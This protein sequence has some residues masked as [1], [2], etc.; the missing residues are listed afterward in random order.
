MHQAALL[1]HSLKDAQAYGW[2][3]PET[4]PF[5]WENMSQAVQNHVRSLNFAHRVKLKDKHVDFFNAL[6]SLVD[7][8]TVKAVDVKGKER[9]LKAENIV[10]AV[11]LRPHVLDE[12]PGAREYAITSDDIFWRHEPPG[13]TLVIGASYIALECGGFLT[14]LGFDTTIMV[15]SRCLRSFDQEMAELVT[16][17]MASSG[18]R[19]LWHCQPQRID[20]GSDGRLLVSFVDRKGEVMQDEFNTVMLATGRKAETKGL[21]LEGVGV[22]LNAE[23]NKVVG[24]H[25]GDN[26]RSSVP[27]IYAIG[28]VL[29]GQP[30]LTPVAI[31]AGKM[32][33]HRLFGKSKLQMEYNKVATTVFTP[34]E[35]GCVG[36]AEEDALIKYDED[37]LEIYHAFY[38]PLEFT[39]PE[40]DYSRCY[41][42][43]ICHRDKP[44]KIFG[45]HLIGPNAGEVI[46]GFA[47]ALRC[48]A[49]F[50]QLASTVGI[51]PTCAEE[52]VR[53]H[54]TK[55]SGLDPTAT[56]C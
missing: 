35:Y 42:K 18:T 14:G 54:I 51:H 26:E 3:V 16:D 41:L 55:R 47:V 38:K 27:N 22:K 31:K 2:D 17:H 36:L 39:V 32:L 6:G 52:L 50:D 43:V 30:E 20:K 11:G 40:R 48:G 56:G 37:S 34:L 29:H 45:I 49:S 25:D 4:V 53:V 8:N 15:R 10:I 5:S 21:N 28:D 12:V 9:I 44:Q 33:A 19:F 1:G 7:K 24:G 46:Q 13:K 23:T